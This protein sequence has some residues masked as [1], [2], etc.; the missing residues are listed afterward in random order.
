[1]IHIIIHIIHTVL[2]KMAD[3]DFQSCPSECQNN[4]V[5]TPISEVLPK[6][7]SNF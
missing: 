6:L 7:I 4:H 2:F 1:M 5:I 3:V